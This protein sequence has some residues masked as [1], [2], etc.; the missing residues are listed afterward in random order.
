[1]HVAAIS[2]KTSRHDSNL[3]E[4]FKQLVQSKS[5]FNVHISFVGSEFPV[6]FMNGKVANAKVEQS[7]RNVLKANFGTVEYEYNMGAVWSAA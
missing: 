7:I 3:Q 1:M 4:V 6:P 5:P 2:T